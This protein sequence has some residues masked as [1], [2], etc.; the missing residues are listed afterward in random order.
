MLHRVYSTNAF[1][2]TLLEIMMVLVPVMNCFISP[3]TISGSE[4]FH[5]LFYLPEHGQPSR[6]FYG[7]DLK[8]SSS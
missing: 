6:K 5:I 7:H 4:Q 8:I 1:E 2:H 3:K